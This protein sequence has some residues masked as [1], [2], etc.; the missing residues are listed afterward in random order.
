MEVRA[1]STTIPLFLVYLASLAD[2][3][4][5]PCRGPFSDWPDRESIKRRAAAGAVGSATTTRRLR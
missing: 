3:L 5:Y 1:R 4:D 2:A